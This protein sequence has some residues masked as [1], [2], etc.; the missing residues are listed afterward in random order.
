MF[1]VIFALLTHIVQ[2]MKFSFKDFFSK[3]EQILFFCRFIHI[4]FLN[5]NLHF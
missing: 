3:C 2:K 1:K 4:H 5:E